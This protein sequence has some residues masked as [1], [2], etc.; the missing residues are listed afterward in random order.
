[1]NLS[2]QF[3][4]T[5]G[6]VRR[7][8][9]IS[10]VILGALVSGF[11]QDA[12]SVRG[13]H[14]TMHFTPEEKHLWM[15]EHLL[16]PQLAAGKEAAKDFPSSL[17]LL[18]RLPYVP[19]ERDQ[20]ACGNCWQWAGTGI[21]EIA[22]DVQSGVHD[23]LSLQFINSCQTAIRCCD[24]GTLP[25]FANFYS[26]KGYAIPWSNNNGQFVSAD[27]SCGSAPCG[28]IA[29]TPRYSLTRIST[30]AI[31][32]HGVGQAQ[33]I[34]NIK[35][36]LN[37]NRGVFFAFYMA[38]QTD[39]IQ[40]D[41]FWNS[42]S[43]SALW[44]TF[45]CGQ[46]LTSGGA[47]HGVLCVGYNDDNAGNR[48]WIMVN[49]WG[50]TS[51]R[52]NGIFRVSMDI[53][54]DC[55]DSTGDPNIEWSTLDLE[56]AGGNGAPVI[57]SQPENQTVSQ[58]GNATFNVV[59][60]G[61]SPLSYYWRLNGSSIPG[62]NG[63]SHTVNNVQ[64]SESGSQFSCLVSNAA[65]ATNSQAVTLTVLPVVVPPM[66]TMDPQ[67]QTVNEGA[68]VTFSLSA[69]GTPP[70]SYFW[71]RNGSA[72][73]GANGSSYTL[74]NVQLSD[75][76]SEFSCLVSN[77]AGT[78]NSQTAT[79]TVTPPVSSFVKRHLP[80]GYVVG[81][82]HAVSL[83]AVPPIN[84]SVYAVED[85]PP[86][87]WT[88]GTVSDGGN[89]DRFRGK[90]KYGPYFDN[91]V[92]TLT[93]LV[94]PPSGT[95][96]RVTFAGTG[97]VDGMDSAID[98]DSYLDKF[99]D[100][101]ADVNEDWWISIGEITAYGSCWKT[102]C[103]WPAPPNPIPISYVTRGGALWRGGECYQVDPGV[104][105]APMW[106]VNCTKEAQLAGAN[107]GSAAQCVVSG[108]TVTVTVIPGPGVRTFAVEDTVPP[109]FVISVAAPA[110]GAFD[111]AS[112]K[113]KWGPFFDNQPR[114]LS[115][116]YTP[117]AGFSGAALLAGV[118]S[119]DG[120]DI[121]ITGDRQVVVDSG[122]PK[123]TI[124]LRRGVQLTGA[125]GRTYRVE[126]SPVV[127]GGIWTPVAT[128]VLTNTRQL[129][130]DSSAPARSGSN[131]FYRAVLLP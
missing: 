99:P 127:T 67:S 62:A 36:V 49:S 122:A 83:V 40:F 29:T 70:L 8:L 23:R 125:I 11:A 91:T 18:A 60:T 129:W 88:V 10:V 4:K 121:S 118:G 7:N 5:A 103:I 113:V 128:V 92:R 42:Q 93:Y 64:L 50:T 126:W 81:V 76:S 39:W 117:P 32:T 115:Y 80:A 2:F 34:N 100:H 82:T 120:V 59:A 37:Q 69:T 94:T 102:G 124:D 48:Y 58:G 51:Q 14:E 104:S 47:A 45:Y 123:L 55:A 46:S 116:R 84:A 35:S 108:D 90:V 41:N 105:D 78:A 79:L 1:M 98:G 33:A 25:A 26:A 112:L 109:G 65:G 22:H 63:S 57:T 21:M 12:N 114:T 53:D 87:G 101:P 86:P 131:R 44:S 77:A 13:G 43:E 74:G 89:F 110:E 111:Q 95:G 27:G 9:L 75:N 119:F 24:G 3:V 52:P 20:G 28:S 30:V 54:Y 19:S 96:G 106:W 56:F 73:P 72:I 66:I 85:Q 68:S 31:S 6:D 61:S 97:S 17:T 16:A 71:R 107:G 130:V 38:T 15:A